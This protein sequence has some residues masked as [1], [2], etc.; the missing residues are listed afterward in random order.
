[1]KNDELKLERECRALAR[2]NGFAAWKNEKNGNKGIPDDSFLHPDGRFFL[3]EFKRDE[4]Q[5]ARP[6]QAL[7]LA[8]F[9]KSA[10]LV[11]SVK[12]FCRVLGIVAP[13]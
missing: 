8:R 4:K 11:G 10:H 13:Q 7:W 6:E 2:A 12:E 1:M 5:K 3:V 9:P